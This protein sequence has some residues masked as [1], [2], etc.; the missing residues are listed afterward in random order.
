MV[1]QGFQQVEYKND[2]GEKFHGLTFL[3]LRRGSKINAP[4]E[5]LLDKSSALPR[6]AVWNEGPRGLAGLALLF[7][8]SPSLCFDQHLNAGCHGQ[9]MAGGFF[10][11]GLDFY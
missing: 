11:L 4:H 10:I 5:P 1:E 8:P 7:P 3:S 6:G 9:R 2:V